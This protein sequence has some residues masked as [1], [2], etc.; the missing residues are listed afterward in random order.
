MTTHSLATR[1]A[2]L[3]ALVMPVSV[4]AAEDDVK[5]KQEVHSDQSESL[6]A[7]RDQSQAFVTAFN[8]G[9]AA[10]VAALWTP[11]GQFVDDS[12]RKF[13]G[14]KEIEAAYAEL[15]KKNPETKIEVVV[16]SIQLLSDEAALEEGRT[17]VSEVADG[18]PVYGAY[19]AI[20][21]KLDGKWRMASVRDRRVGLPSVH[22]KIA[23]L[24]WLI[25]KWSAE[26]YGMRIESECR[27]V[28]NKSFVERTYTTTGPKGAKVS[29][30]Q[31]IG[32]NPIKGQVQSWNFSADGGHAT[33]LWTPIE[34]GFT[35]TMRGVTG[36][37]LPTE[38]VNTLTKLDENAYVWQSTSRSI[39]GQP[40]PDT[41]EVVI[42]RQASQP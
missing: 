25:G 39:G 19:A 40:L 18:E 37:G 10:A 23:D 14:Q 41:D 29:G 2:L 9:D 28:A 17:L 15:F 31:L 24:Q 42:K 35:A 5:E 1:A 32:W 7:I 4:F 21:V 8:Q 22:Q 34:N 26:E 20:Q 16:D 27:W 33:G 12:G 6:T 30:V 36:G 11:H 3:V 38:S 13:T